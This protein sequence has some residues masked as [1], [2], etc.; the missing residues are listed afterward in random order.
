MLLALGGDAFCGCSSLRSVIIPD[1]VTSIGEDTF[2]GCSSLRSIII[3]DSVTS[4]GDGA[5]WGCNFPDNL[6]QKLSSRF[7]DKIFE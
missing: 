3:P 4:I 5:F 6:K 2:C 1:S 7:G